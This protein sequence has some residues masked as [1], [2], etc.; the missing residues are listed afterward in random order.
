VP[1]KEGTGGR[2]VFFCG[3]LSHACFC[4]CILHGS[5][6]FRAG[7]C[8]CSIDG[9]RAGV[10]GAG[11]RPCSGWCFSLAGTSTDKRRGRIKSGSRGFVACT[12]AGP[13]GR[14]FRST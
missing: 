9:R 5:R 4:A 7:V 10:I 8:R 12:V 1:I 3:W 6:V 11:G 14:I 13:C 2:H